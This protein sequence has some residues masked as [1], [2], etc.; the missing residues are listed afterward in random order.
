MRKSIDIMNMIDYNVCLVLFR[1]VSEFN[2]IYEFK[3]FTVFA[4]TVIAICSALVVF[5]ALLV[6]YEMDVENPQR[7]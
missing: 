1:I 6:E 3:I 2:A 5:L 7:S 4:W